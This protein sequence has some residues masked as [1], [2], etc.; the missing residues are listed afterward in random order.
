MTTNEQRLSRFTGWFQRRP[1][2]LAFWELLVTDRRIIWCFVGESFKSLLLRADTGE[3]GRQQL[4]RTS[5]EAALALDQRNFA[6]SLASL[7]SVRL[8]ERSWLRRTMLTVT[9]VDDD[10]TTVELYSTRS[11][12]SPADVVRTLQN[13]PELSH[14]GITIKTPRL[15]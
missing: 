14:V 6:V 15:V 8:R 3:R 1:T 9:W 11:R 7:R 2:S 12:A 10:T 4:K 13:R 5:P